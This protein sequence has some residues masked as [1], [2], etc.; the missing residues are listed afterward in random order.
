MESLKIVKI[1]ISHDLVIPHLCIYPET[2][3]NLKRYRHYSVPS[4]TILE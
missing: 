4:N 2:N 1:E 3:N